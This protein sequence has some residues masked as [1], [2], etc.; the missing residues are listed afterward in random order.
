MK[1]AGR[2]IT[3]S[4]DGLSDIEIQSIANL[5]EKRMGDLEKKT[6]QPDTGKLITMV[7]MELAIELYNLQRKCESDK[8]ADARMVDEMTTALESALDKKLF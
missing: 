5:V 8:A 3:M 7:A 2:N 1:I 6:G 4:V